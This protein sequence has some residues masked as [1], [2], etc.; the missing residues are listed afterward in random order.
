MHEASRTAGGRCLYVKHQVEKEPDGRWVAKAH[1]RYG[2]RFADSPREVYFR[3]T[4][5]PLDPD[6]SDFLL[7]LSLIPAMVRGEEL[8]I[9]GRISTRLRQNIPRL[10]DV[11]GV[12]APSFSHVANRV[13]V[14]AE[15]DEQRTYADGRGVACFFSGGVDSMYT[16]LQHRQELSALVFIHGIDIDLDNPAHEGV[17]QGVRRA[18]EAIGLPLVE[19]ET[20]AKTFG[21]RSLHWEFYSGSVLAS[22]ALLLQPYFHKFYIA[23]SRS[24]AMLFA[25]GTHPLLDPLWGTEGL[26]IE[27]DALS[28]RWEKLEYLS[29]SV[30]AQNHLRVCYE[31]R[32]GAYNCG[33]CT[34][35][36]WVMAILSAYGVLSR[37]KTFD[38]PLDLDKVGKLSFGSPITRLPAEQVAKALAKRDVDPE[39]LQAILRAI[40]RWNPRFGEDEGGRLGGWFAEAWPIA[41]G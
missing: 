5:G 23:G 26:E 31:N 11:L 12:F 35:C 37:F 25:L 2:K 13:A 6:N 29:R 28:E 10:Q 7:P 40:R 1:L 20:N 16:A 41:R 4:L 33:E 18:A 36:L 19:V 27:N 22:T 21:D 39:V 3:S 17:I 9:E 30:V 15:G 32:D 38:K 34:K 14:N 8:Q 24:I